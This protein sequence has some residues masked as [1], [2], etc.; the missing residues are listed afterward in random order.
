MLGV[1]KGS[2]VA[3]LLREIPEGSVLEG[4]AFTVAVSLTFCQGG[5]GN[6]QGALGALSSLTTEGA[7]AFNELHPQGVPLTQCA[8]GTMW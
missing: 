6:S 8:E 3:D 7:L 2:P 5:G 4:V 1:N